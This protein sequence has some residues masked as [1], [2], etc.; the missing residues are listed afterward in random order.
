MGSKTGVGGT[1]IPLFD[2]LPPKWHPLP[3]VRKRYMEAWKVA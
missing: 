2:P 1:A 3:Q